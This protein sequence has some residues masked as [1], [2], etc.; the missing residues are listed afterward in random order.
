MAQSITSS[1]RVIRVVGV[2]IDYCYIVPYGSWRLSSVSLVSG[3][4]VWLSRQSLG[5]T[6]T[7][8]YG[9]CVVRVNAIISVA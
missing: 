3:E 6:L 5:H 7:S 1:L 4:L 8:I 9:H 2:L